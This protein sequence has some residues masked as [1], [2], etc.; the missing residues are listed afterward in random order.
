MADL[1]ALNLRIGTVVDAAPNDVARNPALKLWID[2]GD[3]TVAQSSAQLT[4]RYEVSSLVGR[5]VI[6]VTGFAPIRVGG[7]RSDVLVLGAITD[8][9]VVLV[10]PD[11]PV[12]PGT[13]VR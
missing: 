7:F 4:D 2:F 6:A 9:G 5:Q 12:P 13:P 11:E 1:A 8:D 3:E 10:A